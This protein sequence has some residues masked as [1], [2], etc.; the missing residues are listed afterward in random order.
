MPR[1]VPIEEDAVTGGLS[2]NIKGTVFFDIIFLDDPPDGRRELM[3]LFQPA[4]AA[5]TRYTRK[6]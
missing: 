2:I 5:L 6:D 3:A 4:E 1:G